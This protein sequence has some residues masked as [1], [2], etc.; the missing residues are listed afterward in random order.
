MVKKIAHRG[1]SKRAPENTKAAFQLALEEDFFGIECDIWKS[2][3]GK[4]II[5]HDENLN[6]MC[7]VDKYITEITYEEILTHPIVNGVNVDKFPD[8]H[9]LRLEDYCNG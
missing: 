5:S 1:L 9:L 8:Q 6:R 2:L 3:D 7:N 4:Y